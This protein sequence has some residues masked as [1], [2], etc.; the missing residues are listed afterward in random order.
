M[1]KVFKIQSKIDNLRIVE[2][3]ID[4]IS[5]E[6]GLA[7]EA[8]GKIMVSALEAVNNAVVHGNRNDEEKYVKISI[9]VK[10]KAL[11]VSV[12]DEGEGFSPGKI[13]DPTS[14][15]NIENL[16]G[17]GVFLMSRL[18]DRIRFNAK[19]NIVIMTFKDIES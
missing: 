14:P 4:Q 6:L 13:P 18:A 11:T 16:R 15:E 19:G 3:T 17:R 1:R 12:E 8:Y 9:Y 10:N 7:Q 2:K 5:T